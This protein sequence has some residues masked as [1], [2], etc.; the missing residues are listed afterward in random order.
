MAM[1]KE[2]KRVVPGKEGEPEIRKILTLGLVM[3]ER[4]CDGLYYARSMR[5]FRKYMK[6]PSLLETPLEKIVEDVR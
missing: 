2:R 6:D 3:D 5:Y 1:G 4:F